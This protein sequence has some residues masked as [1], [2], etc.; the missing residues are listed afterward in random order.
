MVL[1]R[2]TVALIAASVLSGCAIKN[3]HLNEPPKGQVVSGIEN[4][5]RVVVVRPSMVGMVVGFAINI[6]HVD[7]GTLHSHDYVEA[8]V[9]AGNVLIS[10]R[11]ETECELAFP[12]E[13]G[14]VYYVEAAPKMGWFFARVQ[15]QT[16]DPEEG[17]RTVA[18]C[19]NQT[20]PG[21]VISE[22]SS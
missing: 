21:V 22:Q 13:A 6:N 8:L 1:T 3:V 19:E 4:K 15:L 11:G 9:P 14:H 18:K 10:T 20:R 2:M 12:A 16:L 5:A 17:V 7:V